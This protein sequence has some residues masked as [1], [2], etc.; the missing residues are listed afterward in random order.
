MVVSLV[1]SSPL[2][3]IGT[4]VKNSLS[5]I[6]KNDIVTLVDGV[7]NGGSIEVSAD[8]EELTENV[9]GYGMDMGQVSAKVY[10]DLKNTSVGIVGSLKDGSETLADV[11][12]FANNEKVVVKSDSLLGGDA[13]GISL[14]N[15]AD[16]FNNSEFGPDGEY[17]LG[18]EMEDAAQN[19]FNDYEKLIADSE[20]IAK[21]AVTEFLKSVKKNAEISK[22]KSSI[23]FDGKKVKTTAVS[24]EMDYEQLA[25]VVTDMMEYVSDDKNLEKYLTEYMEYVLAVSGGYFG[26]DEDDVQDLIDEFYESVDEVL[27][28]GLDD[29]KDSLEDADISVKVTFHITKSGKQLV[30][31]EAKGESYGSKFKGS[32]HAGPDLADITQITYSF[33]DDGYTNRGSYTVDTNSGKE[34]VAKVKLVDYRDRTT[35]VKIN[36]DKKDGDFDVKIE[37]RWGDE[38]GVEGTMKQSGKKT[39]FNVASVTSYGEE[40]D[41][42]VDVILSTSDSM[43]S[44]SKFTNVFEMSVDEIETVI[45]EVQ[46]VAMDMVENLDLG[47]TAI[48]PNYPTEAYPYEDYYYE[49]E[50]YY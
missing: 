45:E 37:D 5:A 43:N 15:F 25:E 23:S 36:W 6:Q 47:Y 16:D 20:K 44:I 4:G 32:V 39:T 40:I 31:I 18:F 10:T 2:V 24:I 9:M 49:D 48:A 21:A 17:S 19:A 33:D 27:D 3:L 34:F 11:S 1:L 8:T 26:Y 46:E 22:E 13:Y 38:Y 12:V 41:L 42:G 7:L 30:G 50:Y 29:M 28:D 35:T 14:K